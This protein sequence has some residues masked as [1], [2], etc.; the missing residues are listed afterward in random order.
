VRVSAA[1]V[2][3]A[4]N[5]SV[6]ALLAD[7]LGVVPSRVRVAG[8]QSGRRKVLAIADVEPA[9]IAARWPNLGV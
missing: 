6:V 1:P 7:I 2:D 3:G 8:G 5:A 4:A 9:E